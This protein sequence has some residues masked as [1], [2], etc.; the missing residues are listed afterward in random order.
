MPE[1]DLAAVGAVL[2]Y[3]TRS[4]IAQ[5]EGRLRVVPADPGPPVV[6]LVSREQADAARLAARLAFRRETAGLPIR[7]VGHHAVTV[8]RQLAALRKATVIAADGHVAVAADGSGF[9]HGADR[10][11]WAFQ[12]DRTTHGLGRR[13]PAPGW[14]TALGAPPPTRRLVV[15]EIPA[16]LWLYGSRPRPGD[17]VADRTAPPMR[18]LPDPVELRIV[19]GRPEHEEPDPAEFANYL[20]GLP[21]PLRA[22]LALVPFGAAYRTCRRTAALLAARW[23][24]PVHIVLGLTVAGRDGRPALRSTDCHGE[25]TGRAPLIRQLRVDAVG[26]VRVTQWGTGADGR[27]L[28][29]ADPLR[30]GQA[31]QAYA[32]PAG[33]MISHAAMNLDP[34]EYRMEVDPQAPLLMVFA[35]GTLLDTDLWTGLGALLN[36]LAT[37]ER[38]QLRPAVPAECDEPVRQIVAAI[39]AVPVDALVV[40]SRTTGVATAPAD[41]PSRLPGGTIA[42]GDALSEHTVEVPALRAPT[43]PAGVCDAAGA[44]PPV[45]PPLIHGQASSAA[46]RQRLRAALG[47]NYDLLASRVNRFL[48]RRPGLRVPAPGSD[49]DALTTDLVAVLAYLVGDRAAADAVLRATGPAGDLAFLTCLASGLGRLPTRRG[50]VHLVRDRLSGPDYRTGQLLVEPGLLVASTAVARGPLSY[51]IWSVTGRLTGDLADDPTR[52]N[53]V[54]FPARCGFSVLGVESDESGVRVYLREVVE[55]IAANGP[56]ADEALLRHM[57]DTVRSSDL[58]AAGGP[59]VGSA[60]AVGCAEDGRCYGSD[61]GS[62]PTETTGVADSTG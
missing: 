22:G 31:W 54:I 19:L 34:T 5:V 24:A 41:R 27:P 48:A 49:L 25:V 50:L 57:R 1:P 23:G 38:G 15:H 55:G 29:T 39:C 61:A 56:G 8:A 9:V 60:P 33:I 45:P 4:D 16:G 52:H 17:A 42:R 37:D 7:L 13:L 11:W 47:P 3:G 59:E 18:A 62:R 32:V 51:T 44:L 10:R 2:V 30:L 53:E 36:G 20:A 58:T 12:P 43:G 21:A 40:I 6:F 14:E 28:G 46:E 26:H 35:T